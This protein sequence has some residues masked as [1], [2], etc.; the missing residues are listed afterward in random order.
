MELLILHMLHIPWGDHYVG[1]WIALSIYMTLRML[2]GVW[3]MGT[4]TGPWSYL[5]GQ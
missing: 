2:A 4:G 1:I 3:R 5:R